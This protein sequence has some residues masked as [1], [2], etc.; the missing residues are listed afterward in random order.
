VLFRSA[1]SS[2][3]DALGSFG[4]NAGLQALKLAGGVARTNPLTQIPANLIDNGYLGFQALSGGK[5]PEGS[6]ASRL[7]GLAGMAPPAGGMRGS[8]SPAGEAPSALS[9]MPAGPTL[10]E[11]KQAYIMGVFGQ[12]YPG[13]GGPSLGGFDTLLADFDSRETALGGRKAENESF[14]SGIIEAARTRG[15]DAQ[16]RIQG[17]YDEMGAAASDQRAAEINAIQ[18]SE[19]T[20]LAQRNAAR[21]A[22]GVDGGADIASAE[23]E[24]AGAGISAAG[25]IAARDA[26]IQQSIETQQSSNQLAG[27][28]PM[29]LMANRQLSNSYEDRLAEIA[30]GRAGVMAQRAQ[31]Q[32]SYRAP[33]PSISEILAVQDSANQMFDPGGEAPDVSGTGLQIVQ[34]YAQAD[35]RNAQ[36]YGAILQDLPGVMSQ[37][38]LS[39]TGKNMDPTELANAII[40]VRP[41]YGDAYLFI[42][43]LVGSGN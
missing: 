19:L 10:E 15:T 22:L 17:R 37:Y 40:A 39:D 18:N 1:G 35:P 16:G 4:Y 33:S 42:R 23:N 9:G 38:G 34:Q 26:Q 30:S 8:G 28:D 20:R 7:Q 36:L 6:L 5:V 25:S 43:D 31:A 27:L 24:S 14:I 32:A 12:A 11:Q 3:A 13:G 41:D 21:A 2:A 29:Q